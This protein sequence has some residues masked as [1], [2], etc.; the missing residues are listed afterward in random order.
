MIPTLIRAIDDGNGSL[1]FLDSLGG[2]GK[3]FLVLIFA[4][5]RAGSSI[6]VAVASY[7]IAA[8]C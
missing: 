6:A 8:H 7:G 2:T 4:T 5:V 3:T 1:L